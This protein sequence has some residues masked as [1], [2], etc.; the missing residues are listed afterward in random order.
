MPQWAQN[1][2]DDDEDDIFP[3]E[4]SITHFSEM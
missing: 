3:G 1:D 4:H 2:K